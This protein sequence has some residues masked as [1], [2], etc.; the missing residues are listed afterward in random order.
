[1]EGLNSMQEVFAEK[2]GSKVYATVGSA[3]A[4]AKNPPRKR[5]GG[6]W[7]QKADGYDNRSVLS[8]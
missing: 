2:S 7:A 5:D 1:M 8:F 3:C 6:R 4:S